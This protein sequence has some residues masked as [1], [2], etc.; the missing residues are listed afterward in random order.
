MRFAVYAALTAAGLIQMAMTQPVAAASE[1]FVA[2][3]ACSSLPAGQVGHSTLG[4]GGEANKLSGEEQKEHWRLLFDGKTLQGWA[5]FQ[6]STIPPAWRVEQG[7]MMLVPNPPGKTPPEERGDIRTVDAFGNFELRLQWAIAP[8]GNSGIFFFVREGVEERIWRTAPEMQV[9]DDTRH[10][11]GRLLTHRAGALYDIYPPKCS[12]LKPVGEYND[13]RLVVRDG[14]VE[15]WLNGY[16]IVEYD[17]D[18]AEFAAQVAGSKFKS[19]PLFAKVH[20]GQ[21]GLQDHADEV[22]FRSIRIREL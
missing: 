5:G 10:S 22:R 1:P 6:R 21:L 18:S 8:G 7:V 13:V 14:H 15:H 3:P 16:K 2:Q 17:L 19:A 9:L 12:A 4:L 11:D 20:R